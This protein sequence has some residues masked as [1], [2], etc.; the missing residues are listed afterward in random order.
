MNKHGEVLLSWAGS[1]LIVKAKGPFNDEGALAAIDEI[2]KF[3]SSKNLATW[4]RLGI[5][6]DATLG[7]PSTIKLV[8]NIH[9]WYLENGCKSIAIVVCNS[10]Q[11]SVAENLFGSTA[12]IF[13]IEEDAKEW[14][15]S[16]VAN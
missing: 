10:V 2:N 7:S 8:K 16:Q 14:L 6:D 13:S 11:R 4:Y 9:E 15:F 5:W 12:K 1:I 3:V